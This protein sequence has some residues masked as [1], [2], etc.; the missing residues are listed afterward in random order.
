MRRVA[1]HAP[2]KRGLKAVESG[3]SLIFSH[4]STPCPDEKGTERDTDGTYSAG[5]F[6]SSTPCP[7]E[8]GTESILSISSSCCVMLV[9]L[10]APT[11]RGLKARTRSTRTSSSGSSTPCPDEKGTESEKYKS[12]RRCRYP[13]S[14]PC[15]DE[16]GT[17]RSSD[18]AGVSEVDSVAL[19]APTKRGLKDLGY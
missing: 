3:N 12:C 16:K 7:D 10:H 14:T 11:K 13:C 9:A 8:K 17:E 1:L 19:H 6:E 4:C 5:H 2:T 18:V 15:P